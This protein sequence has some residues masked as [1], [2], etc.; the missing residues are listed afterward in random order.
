MKGFLSAIFLFYLQYWLILYI[1][2][3][4]GKAEPPI[5]LCLDENKNNRIILKSLTSSQS[6]ATN[7]KF[8]KL[9]P[10]GI[11]GTSSLSRPPKGYDESN[12]AIEYLKMKGYIV[13]CP[14]TDKELTEKNL[15]KRS[16]QLFEAMKPVIYFLNEAVL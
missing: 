12:P 2:V 5:V 6:V 11:E 8:I 9:F 14:L 15:V 7:K 16:V 1:Y 3:D 4:S 13:S 10:E